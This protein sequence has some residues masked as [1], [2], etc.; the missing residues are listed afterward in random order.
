MTS[1]KQ[2]VERMREQTED[3]ALATLQALAWQDFE[4]VA[5][6]YFAMC[7]WNAVM[8]KAGADD[9]VDIVL[10][11]EDR[12]ILVQCKHWS[13]TVSV[14]TAREM[15]G[16]FHHHKVEQVVLVGLGGFAGPAVRFCEGKPIRLVS[17][18]ELVAC[19]QCEDYADCIPGSVLLPAARGVGQ[20]SRVRWSKRLRPLEEIY[21]AR[22]ARGFY[23]PWVALGKSIFRYLDNEERWEAINRED[24]I[25][26]ASDWLEEN[27]NHAADLDMSIKCWRKAAGRVRELNQ[28]SETYFLK[29]AA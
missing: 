21:A 10:E 15:Y 5:A 9:G 25:L 11:Y 1:H 20:H 16:L 23:G 28:V 18:I 6:E 17:G 8:T 29:E 22:I 26:L 4:L 27:A 2:I 24:G 7:G 19:I 12:K 14:R 3:E 13:K